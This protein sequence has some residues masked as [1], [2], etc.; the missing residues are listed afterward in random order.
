[1]IR[2][3][4]GEIYVKKKISQGSFGTLYAATFKPKDISESLEIALK[5]VILT[6]SVKHEISI[7]SQLSGVKGF[8][9]LIFVKKHDQSSESNPKV[10]IGNDHF[11]SSR[12]II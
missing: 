9:D 3:E 8:P 2:M 1:M 6:K 11:F 4:F 10:T 7:L 12:T 5:S